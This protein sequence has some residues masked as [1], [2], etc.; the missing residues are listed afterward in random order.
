VL[1]DGGGVPVWL[2]AT[3][4]TAALALWAAAVQGSDPS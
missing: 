2:G 1:L 3:L 4:V